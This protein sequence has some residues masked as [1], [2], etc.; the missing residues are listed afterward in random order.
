[1]L[2]P[3]LFVPVL[4]ICYCSNACKDAIGR[5]SHSQL[6]SVV[7]HSLSFSVN[8]SNFQSVGTFLR[9]VVMRGRRPELFGTKVPICVVP[10]PVTT[11]QNNTAR[12]SLC[13]AR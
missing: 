6:D 9:L 2:L 13:D 10:P 1:M 8:G 11:K 4:R 12:L 7:H 3:I 5:L